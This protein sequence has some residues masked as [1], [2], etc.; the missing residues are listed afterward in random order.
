M[1]PVFEFLLAIT[2]H[3]KE[4]RRTRHSEKN[5]FHENLSTVTALYFKAIFSIAV[6][7]S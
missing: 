4:L 7:F 1:A 6:T 2:L 3:N 5:H